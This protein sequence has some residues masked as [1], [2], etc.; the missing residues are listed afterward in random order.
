MILQAGSTSG[1]EAGVPSSR[2]RLGTG[3]SYSSTGRP[4]GR[5][6]GRRG[7]RR[8]FVATGSPRCVRADGVDM[9]KLIADVI[10]PTLRRNGPVGVRLPLAW[11]AWVGLG[12]PG[13]A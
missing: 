9:S 5:S 8:D 3:G 7:T 13:S 2:E 10:G 12:W 11:F 6:P 4:S 1:G